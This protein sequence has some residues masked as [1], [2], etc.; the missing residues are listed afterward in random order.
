MVREVVHARHLRGQGL[1]DGPAHGVFG[2]GFDCCRTLEDECLGDEEESLAPLPL[3]CEDEGELS[4]GR[5]TASAATGRS[6]DD[7]D[8]DRRVL[9]GRWA[10][11][12][13]GDDGDG[14]GMAVGPL[15]GSTSGWPG[16]ATA[17]DASVLCQR[18]LRG[19]YAWWWCLVDDGVG[20]GRPADAAR[21]H[22]QVPHE[23]KYRGRDSRG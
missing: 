3:V 7:V 16:A 21:R 22:G 17:R 23:T 15:R 8:V 12:P 6:G 20:S 9:P 4:P 5:G 18:G 13:A 2:K 10:R 14:E 11:R 1:D 19:A